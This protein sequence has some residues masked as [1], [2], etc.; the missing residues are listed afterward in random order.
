MNC[1][2]RKGFLEGGW[3]SYFESPGAFC[4]LTRLVNKIK[5]IASSVANSILLTK[6]K[7]NWIALK[8][9]L[10]AIYGEDKAGNIQPERRK[11]IASELRK[12]ELEI[13]KSGLE[14]QA[15]ELDQVVDTLTTLLDKYSYFDSPSPVRFNIRFSNK[16]KIIWA[17]LKEDLFNSNDPVAQWKAYKVRSGKIFKT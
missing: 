8:N 11:E 13:D 9:S 7:R 14:I 3:P 16:D 17:A 5:D 2:N 15:E 4:L 1:C 6:N 10:N 12:I